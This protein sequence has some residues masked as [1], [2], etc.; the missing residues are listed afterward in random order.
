VSVTGI[1]VPATATV[2]SRGATTKLTVTYTP[3]NAD[4]KNVRIVSSLPS[5]ATAA[6]TA[7]GEITITG[8]VKGVTTL[9]IT[10]T[11]NSLPGEKTATCV[12]TVNTAPAPRLGTVT[13]RTA[14][15]WTVGNLI[16]S[17]YVTGTACKKDEYAPVTNSN[18]NRLTVTDEACDCRQGLFKNGESG[19]RYYDVFSVAMIYFYQDILCPDEWRVPTENDFLTTRDYNNSQM[20]YDFEALKSVWGGELGGSLNRF[21]EWDGVGEKFKIGGQPVTGAEA[22]ERIC[23]MVWTGILLD[24]GGYGQF[25]GRAAFGL[26]CVKDK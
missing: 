14:Q 4:N 6:V 3:A 8:V 12:V 24:A 21:V 13:F 1:S 10:S 20:Q 26:R 9:T 25:N 15:T 16:W 2:D 5:V 11:D 7:A 17:D 22:D 19:E 18:L 23:A